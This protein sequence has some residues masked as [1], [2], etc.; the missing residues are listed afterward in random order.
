MI[1]LHR[2][3]RIRSSFSL[4]WAC[5]DESVLFPTLYGFVRWMGHSVPPVLVTAADQR[6]PDAALLQHL[7]TFSLGP[8]D[9]AFACLLSSAPRQGTKDMTR[10]RGE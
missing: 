3:H 10:G 9:H 2:S 6:V 5:L 4:A 7:A 1:H 8:W